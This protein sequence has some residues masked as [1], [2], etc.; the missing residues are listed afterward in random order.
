MYLKNLIPKSENFSS[1]EVKHI[2]LDLLESFFYLREKVDFL[3]NINQN[4]M[5]VQIKKKQIS[6]STVFK[7]NLNKED[8]R[9]NLLDFES[10]LVY[11]HADM[12]SKEKWVN[13]KN[14]TLRNNGR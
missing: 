13:Q 7:Q 12:I 6:D 2:L 11:T 1:I 10:G 14:D 3:G 9:L 8:V 5:I 4:T